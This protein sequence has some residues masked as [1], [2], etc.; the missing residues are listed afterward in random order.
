[1]G[2][3]WKQWETADRGWDGWMA[4][5]TQ[6]TWVWVS[7]GSW[8]WTGRPGVLQYMGSQRVRHDW[9]TELNWIELLTRLVSF[10]VLV[11]HFLSSSS[12]K[13][14]FS[15]AHFSIG[16]FVFSLF[17]CIRSTYSL[18]LNI[19]SFCQ[20]LICAL[21]F[22]LLTVSFGEENFLILTYSNLPIIV[23]RSVCV[24]VF[25]Y[26]HMCTLLKKSFPTLIS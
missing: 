9:A 12:T 21:P 13:L 8:W 7:S 3:Q 16:L 4:S 1:M 19:L 5:L 26:T 6:W 14:L 15:F 11:E 10:P 2:N 22:T 18:D 17:T 24:C 25:V 20:V 23:V